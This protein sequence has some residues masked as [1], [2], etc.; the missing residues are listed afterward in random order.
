MP[1]LGSEKA[2]MFSFGSREVAIQQ[3]VGKASEQK[4]ENLA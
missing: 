1:F 3:R 2:D 4:S